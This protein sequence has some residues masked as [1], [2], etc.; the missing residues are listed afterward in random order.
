MKLTAKWIWK[1]QRS[2]NIYNQTIV[3]RK[4]FR[5]GMVQSATIRITADSFYR[6]Y[7]NDVWIN[8]GPCRSWPEHFQYDQIDVSSKLRPGTNQIRVIA[9]YYGC[10]TMHEIPQQSGL[11]VQLD[12]KL[13]TGKNKTVIS[14]ATWDV[15]EAKGWISNI[16]IDSISKGP[17]E[18]YDARREN[19]LKFSKAHVLYDTDQGPWKNLN[20][21][22]VALLTKKPVSFKSFIGVNIV[23]A[24]GLNFCIPV[25]RLMHPG[26]IEANSSTARPLAIATILKISKKST[27]TVITEGFRD[28][29]FRFAIDGRQNPTGRYNLSS[30]KHILLAFPDKLLG[31]DKEISIR[32]INANKIKLINP[33][34]PNHENPWCF[35]PFSEFALAKNDMLWPD[36]LNDDPEISVAIRGFAQIT[37]QML[38]LVSD[39]ERFIA[40]LG[41]RAKCIPS[42]KMFV[43]D[44]YWQFAHR[45]VV[46]DG[47]GH[48]INPVGLMHNNNE[49][50]TVKPCTSGNIELVYDLGRQ[51]IGYYSIE[52]NAEEG[53][54]VDI[55][56]IEYIDP[57]GNLQ[58]TTHVRNGMRYITRAGLNRFVSLKRRSGRYLFITIRNN[59]QPVRIHHIALIESTYPVNYAGDFKCS[60]ARLEKIWDISAHTLK[61]CMEDVFTDCPLYEQ[62]LWVGDARNEAVFAY[63]V[64][65]AADL[66]KRCIKLAAQSLERFPIVGCQVPSSWDVLLPAWSF[67]W[68]ISVWDYY[69]YTG[70]K[71]FLRQM[72]GAVIENLKGAEK[73]ITDNGL[74][75]APFW[76]LFDWAPIDYEH[77]T[78]LYNSMFIIGAIDAALKCAEV[79][80]N[81]KHVS[82]LRQF[83]NRLKK[84]VNHHWDS[85]KK[86]YP[87]SIHDDGAIS[88]STCRHT[89]FLSI[90]YDIIEKKNLPHALKNIMDP[91]EEMVRV[92]SPFAMMYLYEA[93][94]KVGREDDII[95]SIYDNYLPMLEVD[96]TTV[97]EMF[98]S[99]T[100][101]PEGFPTRSH[102]HAWSSAPVYFLNRIILGV[103]QTAPGAR[104]FEISPRLNGLS[105]AKGAIATMHGPLTIDWR[106]EGKKLSMK[107]TAPD[108]V[109]FKFIRNQTH[110]GLNIIL[111]G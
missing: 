96:A 26:L 100:L 31:H 44:S 60:D 38:K 24:E 54:Q 14:D 27:I 83:R 74:F 32:F 80:G 47:R 92:C 51:N 11:L 59:K 110:K 16:P 89:S 70:D 76:N 87:D 75:S 50:T 49:V 46:G 36:Q 40:K 42:K 104:E 108:T 8:D 35:I 94:E 68:G 107:I 98:P 69:W 48:V 39:Q 101:K 109:R 72:F 45:K 77:K 105:R 34:N 61:L 12:L 29:G 97:W 99:G 9:Q 30:G 20:P 28:G 17:A 10:G 21:R 15:A 55:Y 4:Q 3:A 53:V 37:E 103:K 64:F 33:V 19:Q 81:S 111:D 86:T 82:W 2:C 18:F 13:A 25:T 84:A 22:D 106:L 88:R 57:H 52:L 5:S 73:F 65:G 95:E 67:L 23:K 78:V 85:K 56:G 63:H 41:S 43:E 91:P 90:L 71:K 66:A 62:T 6:L 7:I 58:H 79:S 93:L 1:K 102:C